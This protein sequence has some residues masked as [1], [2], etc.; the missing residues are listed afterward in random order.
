MRVLE[1]LFNEKVNLAWEPVENPFKAVTVYTE[2]S[3]RG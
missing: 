1:K 3:K 2:D